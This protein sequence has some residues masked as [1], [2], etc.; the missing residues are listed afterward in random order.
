MDYDRTP[1]PEAYDRGRA[2]A[3][4]TLALWLDE[5][6]SLLPKR[7]ERIID[8]GC[9]T[10]R[11]SFGLA[12]AYAAQLIGVDPSEKML[13]QARAKPANPEVS[14]RT[15][16]AEQVP[17][18]SGWADLV[19]MSMVFHHIEGREEAAS[20]CARVLSPGGCVAIRNPTRD[21]GLHMP[22]GG[23]FEG[24]EAIYEAQM[25]L[26]AE[27]VEP[28]EAAGFRPLGHKPIRQQTHPDWATFVEQ[29]SHRADSLLIRLPDDVFQAGLAALRAHPRPGPVHDEVDL[30]VLQRP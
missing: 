25:P 9:G 6:A 2:L 14:F 30:I 7:P 20:E 13:A 24:L 12:E 5:L 16:S 27:I 23:W 8:L 11:F 4:G 19:F 21:R 17:V 18:E 15:G 22:L 1:M 26:L 28:F 3:P 29:V 10:G